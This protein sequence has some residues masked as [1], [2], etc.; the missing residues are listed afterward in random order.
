MKKGFK[1]CRNW[2]AD[3]LLVGLTAVCL[4]P[5]VGKAFNIDDPLFV[6]A[7]QH[8]RTHPLNPYG[9]DVNW[10][11]QSKPMWM[12]TK[13]PPLVCYYIAF[14]SLLVGWREAGIHAFLFVPAVAAVL[15]T[16]R[17]AARMCK[18]PILATL[19]C[20]LTP[21]FVVSSTTVMC[22]VTMLA[23][24]VWAVEFWIRGLDE[25]RSWMNVLSALLMAAAALSK[26]YG[27]SLIPLLFVYTVVRQRRLGWWVCYLLIPVAVLAWYQVA[28][29]S[30]YGRGLLTDAASYATTRRFGHGAFVAQMLFVGLTF[31]G[32]CLV[33]ALFYAPVMWRRGHLL[34]GIGVAAAVMVALV[35]IGSVGKFSLTNA[36]GGP[37]WVV[38]GQISVFVTVGLSLIALCVSD[39]LG[40]RD[41][42]SV[43]LATW[44]LGTLVFAS[45]INWS[46]NGRSILPAAPAVGILIF[47]RLEIFGRAASDGR[48]RWM[49]APLIPSALLSLWVAYGD[50][51]YAG[52]QRTAA[53]KVMARYADDDRI[54][55]TE[56]HWGFQ[57]YMKLGGAVD[58]DVAASY[59]SR[60]DVV[61]VPSNNTNLV[62]LPQQ[63]FERCETIRLPIGSFAAT[64]QPRMRASFYADVFGPMPY[65]VGAVP[66]QRVD[67]YV[68]RRNLAIS[69]AKIQAY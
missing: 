11:A 19:A 52:A 43:L 10:Y 41:A 1:S 39:V 18:N 69:G 23:L 22:D 3:L 54:V 47:R 36:S 31:A 24:W 17:L 45:L 5:F 67:I 46:V 60:G 32:G 66:D 20:L 38:V 13:N 48:P 51:A 26:Y 4:L 9:F 25:R 56:G 44:V 68:V 30:L 49:L 61:A 12:V 33:S 7:A 35:R 29:E 21:V 2:S 34:A 57:Y 40:R 27:M 15:G 16:Y 64:L 42:D 55:F 28:T 58:L 62:V 37:N 50:Y 65:A 59:L 53:Y 6:W 63:D 8:I 14:V